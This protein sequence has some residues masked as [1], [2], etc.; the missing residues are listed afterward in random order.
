MKT[1]TI[2]LLA[3]LPWLMLTCGKKQGDNSSSETL[4]AAQNFEENKDSLYQYYLSQPPNDFP[5]KAVFEKGKLYPEDG[6]SLDTSF[7]IYR[8]QMLE[9]VG[10]KDFLALLPMLDKNIKCSFGTCE[11]KAGFAELWQLDNP[12]KVAASEL[13]PILER[14][15]TN[16]GA[17]D[18]ENRFVAPYIFSN[19]SESY[20]AFEYGLIAGGGVRMRAS[21]D[22]G[23]KILK[24]LSHDIVKI[25]DTQGP[26]ETIG[27]ETFPWIQVETLDGTMGYVWGKF[28]A[29]S[30]DFRAGFEKDAEGWGMTF[31]LAGD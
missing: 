21:P 19:W 10:K 11:G 17:F 25:L 1:T 6:A 26:D 12:E 8:G 16:G 29:S 3:I 30:I 27:G 28:V 23:S 5:T 15:L 13:W 9:A 24:N 22:L 7:F 20:D 18:Q 2:I 4:S 31:F 14:V